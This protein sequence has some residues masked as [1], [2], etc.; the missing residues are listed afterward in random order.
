MPWIVGVVVPILLAVGGGVGGS[1]IFLWRHRLEEARAAE[2]RLSS[3]RRKVY[4]ELLLPYVQLL[5][6]GKSQETALETIMSL[7]NRRAA[8]DFMLV[9][10]DETVRAY[11]NLM[12]FI[13]KMDIA[14]PNPQSNQLVMHYMGT[15]LLEIR[16]MLGN[17]FTDLTAFDMLRFIIKD[18]DKVEAAIAEAD[19]VASRTATSV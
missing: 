19:G 15:L 5:I 12:Q 11:N 9:A 1:I 14:K 4:S 18:I 8:F 6:P 2:E 3:D 7:D 10:P 13:F 17:E 16:K